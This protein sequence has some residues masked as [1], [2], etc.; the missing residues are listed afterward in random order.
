[1]NQEE[2]YRRW[3]QAKRQVDVSSDFADRVMSQIGS[4]SPQTGRRHRPRQRLIERID[5]S[6]WA[7]VAAIVIASLAG[8][9]RALLTLHLLLSL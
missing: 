7:K 4:V 2:I 8:L 3:R 6:A 1:M 9:G 5:L